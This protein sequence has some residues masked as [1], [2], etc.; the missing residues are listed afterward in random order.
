M[1]AGTIAKERLEQYLTEKLRGEWDETAWEFYTWLTEQ[2]KGHKPDHSGYI[3][4]EYH[5]DEAEAKRR[6]EEPGV[7]G[8]RAIA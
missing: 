4:P 8:T 1:T 5:Q 6:R 3:R 7:T 2:A